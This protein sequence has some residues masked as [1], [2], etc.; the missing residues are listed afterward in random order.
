MDTNQWFF[1]G[2]KVQT[3]DGA[4][5]VWYN[6]KFFDLTYNGIVFH[7]EIQEER[8]EENRLVIKINHRVFHIRRK[9]ELDDL[10]SALGLDKVK[11][12]KIKEF[13]SPMPGR[14]ID[15]NV[16]LGQEVQPGDILISLEA[17]K[18]ENALKSE[19][20]GIVKTIC[21]DKGAVVDKGAVLIEFE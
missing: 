21:I 5:V 15:I 6:H 2:E 13:K 14:V 8:S 16:A 3:S 7:G 17:M 11:I 19:G 1:D 4:F 12:K 20:V 10:I 9:H 18:M